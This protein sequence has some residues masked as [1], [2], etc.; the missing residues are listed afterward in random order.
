M[1]LISI[2]DLQY[3]LK[4]NKFGFLGESLAWVL[5]HILR[6]NKVNNI[7]D[8]V[9]NLTAQEAYQRILDEL[10]VTYKIHE[11]D[12][13]RIPESGPFI[14]VSNHPL[15]A[16]DGIILMKIISERR[17]D[18]KIMSNFLLKKIEPLK[19]II[20]PVNPFETRKDVFDNKTPIMEA[21]RYLKQDHCIAMFPAG[22]VSHYN[23]KTKKYEDRE[24][25]EGSLKL[26]KMAKVPIIPIYF[27][28]KN[29]NFFY[30]M[31]DIHPDLQTAMLPV[32]MVRKR[33]KPIQIRIGKSISVKQQNDYP[34]IKEY[35]NFIR[36][37][38]YMLK[39]FYTVNK[40]PFK[41][42]RFLSVATMMKSANSAKQKPIIDETPKECILKEIELLREFN[43]DLFTNYQYEVF[44]AKPEKIPNILREIGRLREITFR[45]VGEGTNEAFDLDEFDQFYRHLFLWDSGKQAIV[46]SYRMGMGEE[47][48]KKHG[49]KGF[50]TASLFEYDQ[51][52]QPFFRKSI[53]MGRAFIMNE[54]QQKPMPLFLLWKGIVHVCLRN[55]YYKYLI[56]GVSI[57]NQFSNFSK[58]IM[59]EFMRSHYYDAYVAQFVHP[60]NEFKVKLNDTE[61]DL[62]FGA[63]ENDLNKFDK[64][65]DELEPSLR[66]PVLIKKYFKQNARVIAFNVDPKFNDAIDGLMYIRISDIPSD[67]IKPVLDELQ[68]EMDKEKISS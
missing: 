10:K 34:T 52:I 65:I 30:K 58:S 31:Y 11:E 39:S 46:G 8:K 61:K 2:K 25:L 23:R 37:K 16:L 42:L 38:V 1:S 36:S 5:M 18:F 67:T 4:L 40:D 33:K 19:D 45:E 51:E 27:H 13:K 15:G 59:V 7:Y 54:F 56:G 32:E 49:I 28:A 53:E 3:V 35:G 14:I 9:K 26:M 68:K 44:F 41:N 57:S 55:P 20:I 62:F 22:E 66:L 29:S 64:L 50:Y 24:W 6:L 17:S 48:Y 12:L 63:A 47:I 21:L 60:K 43:C